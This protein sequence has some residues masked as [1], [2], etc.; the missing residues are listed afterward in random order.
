MRAV[1]NASSGVSRESRRRG[2]WTDP[3]APN[4]VATPIQTTTYGVL[5][6]DTVGARG[7]GTVT[8]TVSSALAACMVLVPQGPFAVQANG[9]CST[10]SI[11]LYRWWSDYRSAGQPPSAETTTPISPVFQYEI[12]DDHTVRLEVVD[13]SGATSATTAVFTSG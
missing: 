3:A 5:I 10:G 4:P 8:V 11:V 12:P 13:S 7:S 9:S 1:Q 2:P 6:T